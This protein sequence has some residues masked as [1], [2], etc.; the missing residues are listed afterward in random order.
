MKNFCVFLVAI[1]CYLPSQGQRVIR[2]ESFNSKNVNKSV[3]YGE[4]VQRLGFSSG[5]FPQDV[6]IINIETNQIYTFRVKSTFKS[7]KENSFSYLIEP[8][9]Y[10]I[11]NYIWVKSKWYGGE[12]YKEPIYANAD[13]NQLRDGKDSDTDLNIGNRY[14]FTI[15]ENTINYLGT[16]DFSKEVVSFRNEKERFDA[17]ILKRFKTLDVKNANVLIPRSN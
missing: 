8:G 1:L 14:I 4:F 3:I 16:W 9:S 13:I 6:Q 15:K 5:G 12:L 17:K 7:S 10:A 11:Y 2:L